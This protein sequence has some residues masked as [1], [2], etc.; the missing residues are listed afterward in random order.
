VKEALLIVHLS[1]LDSFTWECG[2]E[3]G[4]ALA[5]QLI[6][7][8]RACTGPIVLIDPRWPL[9]GSTSRPRSRVLEWVS[10]ASR[11]VRFAHD[12]QIEGWERPMNQL[13]HLLR[14]LDVTHLRIG[15]VWATEHGVHGCVNET[16]KQL[17]KQGFT[18]SMDPSICGFEG[19][20]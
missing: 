20:D 16:M 3:K 8:L 9:L 14:D 5:D 7:A 17:T 12:E 10:A 1:S 11:V 15:G 2:M 6:L 18:C 13:G 19:N 4:N